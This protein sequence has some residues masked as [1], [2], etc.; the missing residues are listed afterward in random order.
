MLFQAVK[1][2]LSV[3]WGIELAKIGVNTSSIATVVNRMKSGL[4]F[5]S[6]RTSLT[7][8][9][10]ERNLLGTANGSKTAYSF[11][12]VSASEAEV[13]FADMA[14]GRQVKTITTPKGPIKNI[15]LEGGE[16][17]QFRKWSSTNSG[18]VTIEFEISSIRDIRIE[19]KFFP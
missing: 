14:A 4:S 8:K 13:I 11:N 9:I 19:L 5:A 2:L 10:A 6:N 17:V 15:Q 16:Y 1:G 3:K 18:E 7:L 12:G